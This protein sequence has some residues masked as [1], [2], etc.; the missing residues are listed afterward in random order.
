MSHTKF[1]G[2][3]I[4]EYLQW[5]HHISHCTQKS[6]GLYTINSAKHILSNIILLLDPSISD[7][8][9]YLVGKYIYKIL[10]QA[11]DFAIEVDKNNNMFYI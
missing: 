1:L 3:Y 10:A 11:I 9:N 4:D 6:I 5:S 2:L 8:W 7:I